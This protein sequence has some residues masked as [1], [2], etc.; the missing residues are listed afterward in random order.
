MS[1]YIVTANLHETEGA[2]A[3]AV[4]KVDNLLDSFILSFGKVTVRA[5]RE[6][7]GGTTSAKAW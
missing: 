4:L 6:S 2:D 3:H 1:H 5:V 7:T